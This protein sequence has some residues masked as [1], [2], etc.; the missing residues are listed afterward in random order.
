M[1][2]MALAIQQLTQTVAKLAMNQQGRGIPVYQ[3]ERNTEDRTIRID[4]PKFGG[5]NHNPEEYLDWEAEL[6]R[7][8]E[9]RETPAEQKYKLAKI[10]LNKLAAIWLEGLQ[11]QRI[12]ENREGIHTWEKLKKH[13][14]R[15]YVP[16]SYKQQLFVQWSTLRQGTKSVAD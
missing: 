10:K 12:R 4:V 6:E 14:R 13:L 16:S 3:H 9:F 7:Y 1:E 15:K 11:K 8:F 5:M 2:E